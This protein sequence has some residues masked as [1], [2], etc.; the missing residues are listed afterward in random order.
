MGYAFQQFGR[1]VG[2]EILLKNITE[3]QIEEFIKLKL[4]ELVR[5]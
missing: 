3:L 2:K 5:L 4:S 1:S